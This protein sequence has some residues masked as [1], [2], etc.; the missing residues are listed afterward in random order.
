MEKIHS[1]VNA[2]GD[3]SMLVLKITVLILLVVTILSQG[4]L[5]ATELLSTYE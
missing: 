3:N 1:I 2:I 5:D 4:G